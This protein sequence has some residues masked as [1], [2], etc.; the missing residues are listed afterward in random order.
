MPH[1]LISVELTLFTD[2]RLIGQQGRE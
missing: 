2:A 1:G